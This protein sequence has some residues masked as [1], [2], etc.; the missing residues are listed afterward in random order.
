MS[1]KKSYQLGMSYGTAC[2]RLRK[3]V[4]FNLLKRLNENICFQC[5]EEI[6]SELELSIEHKK[7]WLDNNVDLFWDLDNIAFSHL[8]CNV[9]AARKY[10]KKYLKNGDYW[11]WKC[12]KYLPLIKFPNS[13]IDKNNKECTECYSNYRRE[14]RKRDG[15]K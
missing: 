1:N 3:Q 7:P 12:K 11:C 2:H 10:N 9:G 4:M 6:K 5:N 14:Y 15:K 8:S 13:R